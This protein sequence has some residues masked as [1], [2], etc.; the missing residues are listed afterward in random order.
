MAFFFA[1]SGVGAQVEAKTLSL[2]AALDPHS[3][4]DAITRVIRFSHQ[5]LGL[6]VAHLL[7]VA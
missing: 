3:G 6:G 4:Q 7:L 5:S 2:R 1:L